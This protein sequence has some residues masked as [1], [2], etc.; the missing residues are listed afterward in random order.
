VSEAALLSDTGA[1]AIPIGEAERAGF[2]DPSGR[3][4][5]TAAQVLLPV[6]G[7]E[8][9]RQFLDRSL[10]TL[11]APGNLP[12]VAGEIPT[13]FVFLTC[14]KDEMMIREH[15]AYR[16]LSAVCGVRFEAIDDLV[17]DGNHTTTITLAY[18]R[19]VRR[20]GPA[21]LDTCFFFLVSDYLI[22]DGS[23]ASVM[24]RMQAGAS[25][26]QVGNFQ[27]VEEEATEWL[28][29]RFD[30]NAGSVVLPPRELMRWSL[31]C[32]HPATAANTVNYP[33]CHNTH[34]N[35]LFWRV[36]DDTLI[37]RF[38]LMHMICVRPETADFLIGAS[39]DYSFVPEMCPSGNIVTLADSDEYLVIEV[40]PRA[41]E[42]NLLACGPIY[43]REIAVSL[44]EWTT[45]RHR[46]NA[47]QTIVFH[48]D[49]LPLSLP[50]AI[51]EAARFTEDISQGLS[52][53]PQPHRNHPYWRG[54]MAAF[55]AATGKRPL[56]DD[57]RLM[58]RQA[59]FSVESIAGRLGRMLL[60]RAPE[61][62]RMHPRWVDFRR[63]RAALEQILI[64]SKRHILM[65]SATATSLTNWVSDRAPNAIRI[66]TRRLLGRATVAEMQLQGFEAC[67]LELTENDFGSS[68][69]I[70]DA[71]MPLLQPGAPILV[72]S[73]NR[74]WADGVTLF[75]QTFT[76]HASH[77]LRAGLWPEEIHFASAGR[78]RWWLNATCV[79]MAGGMFRGPALYVPLRAVL[80][81][82]LASLALFFNLAGSLRLA[83]PVR[84]RIISSVFMAFRP[85]TRAASPSTDLVMR[86]GEIYTAPVCE[87]TVEAANSTRE[88]QYHRLLEI[89]D[90]VGVA[91]LGLM[92]NQVW[93]EDPRRLTFILARYKFVAKM[94]SGWN[95]VAEV[96]CGDAFGTRIVQ[97]EVENV[98]VYD[99]D[100]IF[101]ED[102][103]R[104]ASPCWPIKAHLH[105][106]LGGPL[107]RRHNAIFSLDV[108]EHI[109]V[110][111][112]RLFLRNLTTSLSEEGVLIVGTPSLESQAYASPQSRIGHVNCKTG[113]ALKAL[114]EQYFHSV[115]LFSMNDEVV[116]TGFYPMA[117]YLFAL[118]SRP[119]R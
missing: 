116:H 67:L 32:I 91:P 75:G 87:P 95:N 73:F 11:L 50:K 82:A 66:P 34:T 92:T 81:F 42:A 109:P 74:R 12:A 13:E 24:A 89:R 53:K 6:W 99:F 9:V 98:T 46:Q 48:A 2:A 93:H 71:V 22:A 30:G 83:P 64:D 4:A 68:D 25:G 94:L 111:Q 26:V 115:F 106:I 70:I 113:R 40:Q 78:L 100:P 102:I 107:P 76:A 88:P 55:D 33:V 31:T 65:V 61:V 86:E 36:N 23:L 41:H 51:A 47:Q 112:E 16:R 57:W 18:A 45:A 90:E 96:G 84:N 17:T 7:Y 44:S 105:D 14:K 101:I 39:C 8:F 3:S 20:A 85:N 37:G 58:L 52:P 10:P 63:P 97:Q 60:G 1:D 80:A 38:Y 72:V 49:E 62:R 77:F 21:M 117:H 110:D 5:P 29:K 103:Q 79:R 15:P 28:R 35:R 118:C 69:E 56:E 59:R 104:R 54:A 114:L 27:V 19:A 108:I 43:P 119:K